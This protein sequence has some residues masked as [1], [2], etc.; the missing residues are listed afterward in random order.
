MSKN[1]IEEEWNNDKT[2]EILQEDKKRKRRPFESDREDVV[3]WNEHFEF[4]ENKMKKLNFPH[5]KAFCI[6]QSFGRSKTN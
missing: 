5:R 4:E 2:D 1:V 3:E 6:F